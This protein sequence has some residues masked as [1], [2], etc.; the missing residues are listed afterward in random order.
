M[1]FSAP[2]ELD[3]VRVRVTSTSFSNMRERLLGIGWYLTRERI[4]KVGLIP[5]CMMRSEARIEA[6]S[7]MAGNLTPFRISLFHTNLGFLRTPRSMHMQVALIRT[8]PHIGSPQAYWLEN[9][10]TAEEWIELDECSDGFQSSVTNLGT[11]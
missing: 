4:K 10:R 6:A 2:I 7:F 9:T 8:P 11:P 5:N 1:P 3:S